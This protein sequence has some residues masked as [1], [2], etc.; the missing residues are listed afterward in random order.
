METSAFAAGESSTLASAKL[1]SPTASMIGLMGDPGSL[2]DSEAS[3]G[4]KSGY[5]SAI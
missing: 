2:S 4:N 1:T 5:C 3:W